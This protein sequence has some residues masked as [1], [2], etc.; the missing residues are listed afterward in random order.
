MDLQYSVILV[1]NIFQFSGS[2]IGDKMLA[3]LG[4]DSR[5]INCN[6]CK[7]ST[8]S[9]FALG[10][11]PKFSEMFSSVIS[12]PQ[13]STSP[14]VKQINF[15]SLN[16]NFSKQESDEN[17][18]YEEKVKHISAHQSLHTNDIIP[19]NWVITENIQVVFDDM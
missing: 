1:N 16:S 12:K 5:T 19:L 8:S 4:L 2:G 9:N 6:G 7:S 18:K 15:A 3:L 13:N 11:E 10:H 14:K 17:E